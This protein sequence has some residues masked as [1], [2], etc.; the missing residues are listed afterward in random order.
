LLKNSFRRPNVLSAVK[1]AVDFAA[2]TEW[3]EAALLQN[4]HTAGVFQQPD[5]PENRESAS[6]NPAGGHA[7]SVEREVENF[8]GLIQ[9]I[10]TTLG[11]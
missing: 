1:A 6:D 4:G 10:K 8:K 3:L 9:A 5:R 2:L 7:S 11:Q